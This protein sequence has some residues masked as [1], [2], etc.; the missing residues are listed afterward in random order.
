MKHKLFVCGDTH[1]MTKDTQ[2][3]N[4]DNFPEQKKLTKEDLLIQLGDFGWVWFPL[5]K[6]KEQ[7][8]WL[9]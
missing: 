4:S 2:K 9:E 1:G 5:G 3:L 8:Y 7:E 6:N